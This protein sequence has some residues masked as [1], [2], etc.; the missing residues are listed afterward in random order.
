MLYVLTLKLIIC[1]KL[2]GIAAMHNTCMELHTEIKFSKPAY[3]RVMHMS[4]ASLF[5]APR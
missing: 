3:P 2:R 4:S 5:Q 1:L